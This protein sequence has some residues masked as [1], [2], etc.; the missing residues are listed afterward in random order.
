MKAKLRRG[1]KEKRDK[2]KVHRLRACV[3]TFIYSQVGFSPRA[4]LVGKERTNRKTYLAL[5]TG[6]VR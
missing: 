3:W 6:D 5:I 4:V 1:K 2:K